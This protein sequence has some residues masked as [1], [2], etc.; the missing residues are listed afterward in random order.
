[1]NAAEAQQR[2][3]AAMIAAKRQARREAEESAPAAGGSEDERSG[4]KSPAPTSPRPP[5]KALAPPGKAPAMPAKPPGTAA[6]PPATAAK[7]PATATKPGGPPPMAKKPPPTPTKPKPAGG[8]PPK[9]K[10]KA[11]PRQDSGSGVGA[12]PR[13]APEEGDGGED[14]GG[15]EVATPPVVKKPMFG[16]GGGISAADLTAGLKARTGGSSMEEYNS[17]KE[18]YLKWFNHYLAPRNL[19]ADDL[20]L[21][22]S[23]GV[24]LINA[25]EEATGEQAGKYK[26]KANFPVHCIDNLNV[27]LALCKKTGIDTAGVTA[28]D[29]HGGNQKKVM[30]LFKHITKKYPLSE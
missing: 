10:P 11:M 28:E 8:P 30:V 16:V 26:S 17:D 5:T 21:S 20:H 1:M 24:L 27:A 6:K 15:E 22:L 13:P 12:A 29:I 18:T 2:A 4:V 3:A 25:L 9:P 14:T 23:T 7:P 19:M